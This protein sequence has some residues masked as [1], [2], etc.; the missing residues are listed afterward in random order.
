MEDIFFDC[1]SK[2]PMFVDDSNVSFHHKV[3]RKFSLLTFHKVFSNMTN[4][5]VLEVTKMFDND[6]PRIRHWSILSKWNRV[7]FQHFER[8]RCC[9]GD[10]EEKV[11]CHIDWQASSRQNEMKW[12]SQGQTDRLLCNKVS[13]EIEPVE[14]QE[15]HEENS[16]WSYSDET[17][18][19][20]LEKQ[21]QRYHFRCVV[22][23][24][25]VLCRFS[26][27]VTSC[28]HET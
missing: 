28:W 4:V 11:R 16:I 10:E 3:F 7:I 5:F 22:Y 1:N 26:N 20:L 27:M 25:F 14:Q 2:E 6:T 13:K 12:I 19:F 21:S 8:K 9:D 15:K 17:V 18:C 24:E 23:V